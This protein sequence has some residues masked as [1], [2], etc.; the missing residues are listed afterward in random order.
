MSSPFDWYI[1]CSVLYNRILCGYEF[2]VLWVFNRGAM[3]LAVTEWVNL[4]EKEIFKIREICLVYVDVKVLKVKTMVGRYNL[5]L[6][7]PSYLEQLLE[8][9]KTE[10]KLRRIYLSNHGHDIFSLHKINRTE[11]IEKYEVFQH[12]ELVIKGTSRLNS[13]SVVAKE[14]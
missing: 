13:L 6:R 7:Y 2:L 3:S 8:A 11:E 12:G 14:T 9:Y 1:L 10:G 4:P 5:Y